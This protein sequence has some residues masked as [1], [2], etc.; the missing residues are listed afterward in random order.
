MTSF[1]CHQPGIHHS[2]PEC[3]GKRVFQ[4]LIVGRIDYLN[5]FLTKN[6]QMYKCFV[7]YV[8]VFVWLT[9]ALWIN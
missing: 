1:A 7:L 8:S 6:K 4:V 2:S 5:V 3:D 9:K